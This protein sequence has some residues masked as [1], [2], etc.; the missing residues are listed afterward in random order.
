[1]D[2]LKY[3]R[4]LMLKPWPSKIWTF[5]QKRYS[6]EI[7]TV[8]CQDRVEIWTVLREDWTFSM[9]W[10]LT[11]TNVL[12]SGHFRHE[13]CFYKRY[14]QMCWNLD[15][16]ATKCFYTRYAMSSYP[17]KCVEIWTVLCKVWTFAIRNKCLS[18]CVQDHSDCR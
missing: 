13:I 5:F 3:G 16:F 12:K 17:Y 14:I 11:L 8:S 15:I 10:L 4:F 2:D 18:K 9:Q 7:W 1:M 6:V